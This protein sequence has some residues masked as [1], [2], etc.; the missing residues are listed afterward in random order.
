MKLKLQLAAGLLA[1]GI[2]S[3]A[4]ANQGAAAALL[5][6]PIAVIAAPIVAGV[7]VVGA[8]A[9]VA[10]GVSNANG[11][12]AG[13]NRTR[14]QPVTTDRPATGKFTSAEP[15]VFPSSWSQASR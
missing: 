13:H 15:S 1:A 14:Q 6:A 4:S 12:S 7:L 2:A 11:A 10:K 3:P 8:I 5:V 9:L